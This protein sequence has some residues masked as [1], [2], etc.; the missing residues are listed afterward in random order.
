MKWTNA[1][2]EMCYLKFIKFWVATQNVFRQNTRKIHE[3]RIVLKGCVFKNTQF[4]TSQSY[5]FGLVS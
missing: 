1:K 3:L 5:S 4:D 2:G